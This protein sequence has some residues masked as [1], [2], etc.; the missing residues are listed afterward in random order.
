MVRGRSFS[1]ASTPPSVDRRTGSTG[2]A[3]PYFMAVKE[4][5]LAGRPIARCTI[6]GMGPLRWTWSTSSW[7]RTVGRG[8]RGSSACTE[9]RGCR[10][11]HGGSTLRTAR[12]DRLPPW[13]VVVD[14]LAPA[15]RPGQI[16]IAPTARAIVDA[17]RW[18]RLRSGPVSSREGLRP[19]RALLCEAVQRRSCTVE[20]L[21]LEVRGA[22]RPGTALL[23]RALADVVAGCRSA[24]ECELRDV[25][26]TSRILPEPR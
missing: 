3:R 16:P 10:P 15:A 23:H 7:V 13:H 2:C 26:K 8:M 17:L 19:F 4:A 1:R 6:C 21:V 11:R 25:V 22:P 24:P 5:W 12:L 9:P 20:E 14:E 18:M